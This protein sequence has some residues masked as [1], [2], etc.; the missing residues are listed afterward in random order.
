M[1]YRSAGSSYLVIY[2]RNQNLG[3]LARVGREGKGRE[4]S[5]NLPLCLK[6]SKS[7]RPVPRTAI[8]SLKRSKGR[9]ILQ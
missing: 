2:T 9:L 4:R 3:M 7:H 1:R 6:H 5:K 8:H